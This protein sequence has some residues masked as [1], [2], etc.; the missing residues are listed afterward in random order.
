M[1]KTK[2][3][4][5][6]AILHEY[7]AYDINTG[8]LTWIKKPSKKVCIGSRAGSYIPNNGFRV[9]SLFGK[10]YPEHHVIWCWVHGYWTDT[11]LKS[12]INVKRYSNVP[13]PLTN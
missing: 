9:I 6:Q 2:D 11:S 3:E 10:S 4:I 7:L 1:L 12:R 13:I 8:F 5:T